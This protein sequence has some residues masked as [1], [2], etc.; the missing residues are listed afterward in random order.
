MGGVEETLQQ[1]KLE[2]ACWLERLQRSSSSSS[3]SSS[4]DPV[5]EG[6]VRDM[7][8]YDCTL[9]AL[10]KGVKVYL[11]GVESLCCGLELLSEAA[12][13]GLCKKSD[14]W[15][16][17]DACCYR[18]SVHRITRADAPHAVFSRF[19]RDLFFNVLDPLQQHLKLNQQLRRDCQQRRKR[20][21][22]LLLAKRHLERLQQQQQQQQ[23]R[24]QQQ[25]EQRER[26][27]SGEAEEE[28][29]E[30]GEQQELIRGAGAA[31]AAAGAAA[32]ATGAAAAAA[33]GPGQG[34]GLSFARVLQQRGGSAAAASAAASA[35]ATAA[36]TA[37][38][39]A[40]TTAAYESFRAADEELF[41]WL[42]LLDCYKCDIYDSLLQTLK[43]L[44]YDFFAAAAHALA[45]VLPR[46]MEFRPMVEMTPQQ[47]KPL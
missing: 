5:F 16:S 40:A 33:A 6:M 37:A 34:G 47:L 45:A 24:E 22:E 8:Q 27:G 23:Q 38:A 26:R 30:A 17:R 44:Q 19:K 18:E 7:Q 41:E 20:L 32:A 9:Q 29:G 42:Q 12:V 21:A 46:R 13:K 31:A 2:F 4:E 43:Y 11:E 3:S 25:R 39:A 14:F 35:A 15:I 28:D 10:E 1:L 36:A